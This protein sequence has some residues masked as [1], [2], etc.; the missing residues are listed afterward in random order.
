MAPAPTPPAPTHTHDRMQCS[1]QAEVLE[2]EGS[3]T[4][5]VVN[6]QKQINPICILNSMQIVLFQPIS[7]NMSIGIKIYDNNKRYRWCK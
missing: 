1:N 2:G 4:G 3:C 7:L 5:L 6:L